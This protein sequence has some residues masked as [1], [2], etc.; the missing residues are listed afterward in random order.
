MN[1]SIHP[2][3]G[4]LNTEFQLLSQSEKEVSYIISHKDSG[5]IEESGLLQPNI[6]QKIILSNAGYYD[7]VFGDGSKSE[8]F[9]KDGYK[10]GG[11][12]HKA[13]FI[14]DECP[15]VFVVMRDRTYFHNRNTGEEYVE[16][17]S[18]DSIIEVSDEYVLMQNNG[19]EEVTLYSLVDQ[20]P[21]IC[22]SNILYHNHS[23]LTWCIK[24]PEKEKQE[25]V[26]FSLSQ[27][28]EIARSTYDCISIDKSNKQIHFASNNHIHTIDLS[29]DNSIE[30][31]SFSPNGKFA[32]F[33]QIK[34]AL[35]IES[36]YASKDIVVYEIANQV[37]KN[38]IIANGSI[39]RINDNKFINIYQRKQSIQNFDLTNSDFPEAI[40]SASYTEYDIY[41]CKTDTFYKEQ[42][43]EISSNVRSATTNSTLKSVVSELNESLG[44]CNNVVITDRIFCIYGSQESILIRF[45]EPKRVFHAQNG[46]SI[47]SHGD[48]MIYERDGKYAFLNKNYGF[49]GSL[50][51][52]DFNFS[53]FNDYGIIIDNNTKE[54]KKH[55]QSLG[56]FITYNKLFGYVKTEKG[57]ISRDGYILWVDKDEFVPTHFS[58]KFTYG[59]ELKDDKILLYTNKNNKFSEPKI[60]LE[61]L[62]DTSKYSNA[63][64]SENGHQ[65]IHRNNDVYRMI[66]LGT[67]DTTEFDNLSFVEHING[68]RPQFRITD[69]SQAILI[70]PMNGLPVDTF[71]LDEYQFV[72]PDGKFY[73]DKALD[74]YIEYYDHIQQRL[75]SKEEYLEFYDKFNLLVF[76][77]EKR[78]EKVQNRKNFVQKHSDFLIVVLRKK[79]YQERSTEEFQEILIDEKNIYGI[80]WFLELFIETR[81]I[82]VVCR[83]EDKSEV[84]RINLGKPL[85]F[86]NYVS[87]SYD[88]KYVAIA[89]RYPN[90]SGYSGLFLVYDIE[91]KEII[92]DN[93]S[94]YAVWITA[95][96]KKGDVAAYTSCPNSIICD[97]K[98]LPEIEKNE[99]KSGESCFPVCGVNFLTFSPDGQMFAC[100]KQRYISYRRKDGNIN[101]NWGHQPSSSVS[102]RKTDSPD[103]EIINFSDLSD[104]GVAGTNQRCSVA[105]VSFSN[106]NSRLMMVGRDGCMIIRNLHL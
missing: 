63:F 45:N 68:V 62:F 84:A 31:K 87:F 3:K 104:E 22:A 65:I 7:V 103:V 13:F 6:P 5:A 69:S 44:N 77:K 36:K 1:T 26:I 46:G 71:L 49:W 18:P 10:F 93:K 96:T 8:V 42:I 58:P 28:K 75:I 67:G 52:G 83:T 54:V 102:I 14:F 21:I 76:D 94:S 43:T 100:S 39:A 72:S 2:Y 12:S 89:G 53:Y 97:I 91:N 81:G 9:V 34:Y 11:G 98:E 29:S 64:L 33:A 86:L 73:A 90:Y 27:K 61:D 105:S 17:I 4:Y 38:R 20:K 50:I 59:I 16:S 30:E 79:G 60:I 47:Y 15:W 106:D 85:W 24:D 23:F 41:P 35:F 99:Q 55:N 57:R 51:E 92:T 101:A 78:K 56:K 80:S 32:A 88:N 40:I 74:K 25:L 48:R 19:Q 82:A 37:E 66:D 70:N 95:F